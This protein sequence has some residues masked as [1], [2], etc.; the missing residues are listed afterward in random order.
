MRVGRTRR[1]TRERTDHLAERLGRGLRHCWPPMDLI[2]RVRLLDGEPEDVVDVETS[3]TVNDLAW[4]LALQ[5]DL[6]ES[7][8]SITPCDL[9]IAGSA[10]LPARHRVLGLSASGGEGGQCPKRHAAIASVAAGD[11]DSCG[12][13]RAPR[14]VLWRCS[15]EWGSGPSNLGLGQRGHGSNV[16]G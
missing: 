5:F 8:P 10:C 9:G 2:L 12:E 6:V 13:R 14:T 4:A 11:P 1:S 15:D 7:M 3:H 16:A